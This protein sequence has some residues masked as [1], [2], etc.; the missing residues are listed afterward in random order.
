MTDEI[1]NPEQPIEAEV[2]PTTPEA[3]PTANIPGKVPSVLSTLPPEII[4]EMDSRLKGTDNIKFVREDMIKKYP[5]VEGLKVGY[6]TWR[7]RAKKL[8]GG[9]QK[10][11]KDG[12]VVKK[13]M[14]AAL[15][16]S[17]ELAKAVSTVLDLSTPLENKQEALAALF[18]KATQ[19]LAILEQKQQQFLNPELEALMVTY[20]RE[21]RALLETVTK[22]QEVLQRDTLS[23]FR[24]ELDELIRTILTTVYAA[25]RLNH[26]DADPTSKFDAFKADL[27]S[28]LSK[29]LQNYSTKKPL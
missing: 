16:S 13:E 15:P 29:T 8:N 10:E 19:R 18:N 2:V 6:L 7:K 22:L 14:V 12:T 3:S 20:M 17:E 11:L 1:P 24:T 4:E 25:Y 26:V 9:I 27:E 21:Q 28:H 23:Q 5:G